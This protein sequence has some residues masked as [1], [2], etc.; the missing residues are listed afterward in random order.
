MKL[1]VNNYLQIRN[2]RVAGLQASVTETLPSVAFPIHYTFVR[3][4]ADIV[5][6]AEAVQPNDVTRRRG[7]CRRHA[8]A[9]VRAAPVR[10]GTSARPSAV[11][12]YYS[13]PSD[14]LSADVSI[15]RPWPVRPQRTSTSAMLG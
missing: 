6:S 13:T 11:H 7:A 5:S 14:A 1:R 12:Y 8:D 10:K 9:P 4:R 3:T 15:V 2:A